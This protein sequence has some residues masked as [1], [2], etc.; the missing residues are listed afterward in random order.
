MSY[1]TILVYL[2]DERSAERILKTASALAARNDAHL[3]GLHVAPIYHVY[4]TVAIDLTAEILDSQS[5]ALKMES[6]GLKKIFEDMTENTTATSEW[7]SIQVNSAL[8][9]EAVIN[10]ARCADLIVVAQPD[11]GHDDVSVTRILEQLLVDSGR[12]V[13]MIPYIGTHDEIGKNVTLAW[14]ASRESARA[15]SAALPLFKRAE[16]VTVLWV[17]PHSEEDDPMDVPGSEIASSLARHGINVVTD[18]STTKLPEVGDELLSRIA[19]NGADVLVMGAYGHSRL[20]EFVFGGASR[21]MLQHMTIPV[22]M[23]H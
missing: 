7:R 3:I 19:D 23:V 6:E 9:S 2:S 11:P 5:S 14:N 18:Y 13:L 8:V 1:K 12:P 10:H 21:H 20:R 15:S 22:L 16:K 4:S 17:N